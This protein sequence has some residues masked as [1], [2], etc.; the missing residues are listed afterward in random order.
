MKV[1]RSQKYCCFEEVAIGELFDQDGSIWLKVDDDLF[2]VPCNAIRGDGGKAMWFG[3]GIQV[4]RYPK[5]IVA[6]EGDFT[7]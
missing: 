5:A 1:H 6:L 3:A 2:G 7:E 4:I